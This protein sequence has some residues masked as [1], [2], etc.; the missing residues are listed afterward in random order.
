[1]IFKLHAYP[2]RIHLSVWLTFPKSAQFSPGLRVRFHCDT[3]GILRVAWP[4][5]CWE[6]LEINAQSESNLF[7][8]I[9]VCNPIFLPM[10]RSARQP[11]FCQP[12]GGQ[13]WVLGFRGS[14][15]KYTNHIVPFQAPNRLLD[16]TR[17]V[18]GM[19]GG[20]YTTHTCIQMNKYKP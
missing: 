4:A 6:L 11:F 5:T 8:D 13:P 10:N 3:S 7:L 17:N 18:G 12:S 16:S 19:L 2:M 15:K 20:S 14:Q 9:L 1:M